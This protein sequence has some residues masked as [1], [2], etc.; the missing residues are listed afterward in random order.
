MSDPE[1]LVL[2]FYE[3]WS[4][5]DVDELMGFFADDAIWHNMPIIP[6]NGHREIRFLLEY[7]FEDWGPEAKVNFE[8]LN[9]ASKGNL[10]LSERV[11][12][13]ESLGRVVALPV[14]GIF[15]VEDGKIKHWRDYYDAATL[16]K[17]LPSRIPFPMERLRALRQ[18]EAESTKGEE[19][20]AR[21]QQG[22]LPRLR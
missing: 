15:E 2:D 13:V 6:A 7:M 16:H 18:A 9:V 1:R 21:R 10:V 14:V 5:L 11:D 22:N 20:V 4:R 19:H 17:D 3:A 12:H 8:V